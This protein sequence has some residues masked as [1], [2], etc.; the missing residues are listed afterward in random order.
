MTEEQR[1]GLILAEQGYIIVGSIS[2]REPGDKGL[3]IR[4]WRPD[5]G[6]DLLQMVTVVGPAT[7]D[8]WRSQC[9]KYG[10]EWSESTA[11]LY[12][13]RIYKVITE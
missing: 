12:V 11:C 1:A 3:G 5:G 2:Q 7:L 4:F 8:E 9:Q 13:G 10:E 6:K